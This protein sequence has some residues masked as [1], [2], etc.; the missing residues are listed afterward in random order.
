MS[1]KES[2]MDRLFL[3]F[4]NVFIGVFALFCFLPFWMM[5]MGSITNETVILLKGYS[6]FPEAFSLE[7]YRVLFRS[8]T[9]LRG[10]GVTSFITVVGTVLGVAISALLAYS[11]ANRRNRLRNHFAFFVYFTMLFNGGLVP[12]YIMISNWLKLS[13]TLWAI[14]LPALLQPFLVFLMVSFFRTLPVEL[15]E[16]AR[17]DGANELK[18]FAIIMVPIS[19][20]IIATVALFY[21][22]T[23]WN[24]WFYGLL[25][26][27]NDQIYPL[28]LLLRRMI[29][30]MMAARNLIPAGA[31]TVNVPSLGIRMA[32]TVITIGPIILLYPYMQRYF[33]KGL[34]IGAVKG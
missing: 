22:L 32:M 17:I 16:S 20:P 14:I 18:I 31:A 25:F 1:I 33:V 27:A 7:A 6:L 28:Q 10:Y 13:D 5:L 30:N 3:V 8:S 21:A 34:T 19:K 11:I 26:L 23:Y 4:S 9:I 29:S 24:E 2:G 15:E 12:F